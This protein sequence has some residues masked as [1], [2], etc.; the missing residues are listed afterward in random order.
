M[1]TITFESLLLGVIA[2]LS[3]FFAF[4]LFKRKPDKDSGSSPTIISLPF[5]IEIRS[6]HVA[7]VF[8]ASALASL[9]VIKSQLENS[10]MQLMTI[11]G[12]LIDTSGQ[13]KKWSSGE[14]R[15]IP[16][17]NTIRIY[18]NGV[19][20]IQVEIPKNKQLQDLYSEIMYSNGEFTASIP[21]NDTSSKNLAFSDPKTNVMKY[22]AAVVN[23]F[24][25]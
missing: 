2:L 9:F 3:L 21:L 13:M 4:V 17:K 18:D 14:L 16:T 12:S 23:V 22:K 8:F 6:P 25:H 10:E 5:G 19:Y 7:V 15:M 1:N 20:E 24:P 11:T